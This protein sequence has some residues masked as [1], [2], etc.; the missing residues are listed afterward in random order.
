MHEIGDIDCVHFLELCRYIEEHPVRQAE[1]VEV[2]K[3]T[4]HRVRRPQDDLPPPA[5]QPQSAM[6]LAALLN[7]MSG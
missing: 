4:S 1:M 7:G 2:K 6:E 5:D 3:L